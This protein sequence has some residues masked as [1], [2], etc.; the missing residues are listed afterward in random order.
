M[1]DISVIVPV[2][3]AEAYLRR[4]VDSI[5]AQSY[6]DLEVILVEDGSPDNCGK[7]CREYAAKDPRVTALHQQNQGQ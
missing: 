7:I 2:Y 4:C 1:A 5:L 3:K 6:Q